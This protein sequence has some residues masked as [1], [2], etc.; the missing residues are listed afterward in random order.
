MI[1]A[2]GEAA[3]IRMVVLDVDGTLL[4]SDARL[5]G[6][7]V[8]AVGR[9]RAR[10]LEVCLATS[11]GPSGLRWLVGELG[12]DA[13]VVAYQGALVG[14]LDRTG[15]PASEPLVDRPMPAQ[16]AR[17]VL[18]EAAAAGL[19]V[20]WFAG[21][22]WFAL[23]DDAAMRREAG[24]VRDRF[25]VAVGP[26]DGLRPHKLML[27][28]GHP[29]LIPALHV[30]AGRLPAACA[31][32]FSHDNYLEVT[33]A[34]VDKAQALAVLADRLGIPL[35]ETAAVGDGQNDLGLLGAVGLPIA[36]GNAKP[37]L[38]AIAAFVTG[39][40]DDDGAAAALDRLAGAGG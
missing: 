15:R 10:G 24:I 39:S 11:R 16:A 9:A 29:D 2:V 21:S 26:A 38:K 12:L 13:W 6:R 40:N 35:A 32:Q 22:T 19:S 37:A 20:S 7:T 14:W 31:G 25:V 3:R 28:A 8:A 1:A 34:G 17:A 5:T 36:M 33:R 18:A 23:A 4:T 27:I 30:L